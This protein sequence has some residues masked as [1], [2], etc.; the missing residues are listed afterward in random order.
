MVPD[1]GQSPWVQRLNHQRR[2]ATHHHGGKI[3]M[4]LPD[5]RV[6][7]KQARVAKWLLKLLQRRR[8]TR[9]V[10]KPFSNGIKSQRL[11]DFDEKSI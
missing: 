1:R 11:H 10:L 6:R 5:N 7:P 8:R 2:Q 9:H 4:D 3:G